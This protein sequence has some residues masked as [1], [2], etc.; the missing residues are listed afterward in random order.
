VVQAD[1]VLLSVAGAGFENRRPPVVAVGMGAKLP[2]A[3]NIDYANFDI[4]NV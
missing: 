1:R 4:R 3:D 2:F